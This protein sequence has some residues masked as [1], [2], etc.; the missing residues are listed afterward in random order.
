MGDSLSEQLRK[1]KY[2]PKLS[3]LDRDGWTVDPSQMA[4][5]QHHGSKKGFPDKGLWGE[6]VEVSQRGISEYPV[7]VGSTTIGAYEGSAKRVKKRVPKR[8][9]QETFARQRKRKLA[10][11]KR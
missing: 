6:P 2:G 10:E 1:M 9:P 3:Y 5:S 8:P 7:M 11:K 4:D